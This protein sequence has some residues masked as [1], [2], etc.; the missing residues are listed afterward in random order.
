[1]VGKLKGGVKEE[2]LKI[3]RKMGRGD[4]SPEKDCAQERI[5]GII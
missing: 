4:G 2:N 1:M 3:G 5:W